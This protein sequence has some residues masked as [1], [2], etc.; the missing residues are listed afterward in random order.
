[1]GC[2]KGCP[3]FL[4]SRDQKSLALA[5]LHFLRG[6]PVA[7]PE[8]L[9]D[10]CTLL[11]GAVCTLVTS[12]EP[13]PASGSGSLGRHQVCVLLEGGVWGGGQSSLGNCELQVEPRCHLYGSDGDS[14]RHEE[15][16]GHM[17]LTGLMTYSRGK[18]LCAGRDLAEPAG[19]RGLVG[20]PWSGI[21]H[22]L[23]PH[24]SAS[25]PVCPRPLS[26]CPCLPPSA[27]SLFVCDS[28]KSLTASS[29]PPLPMSLCV[30]LCPRGLHPYLSIHCCH[31]VSFDP[32]P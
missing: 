11:G 13:E 14:L 20:G 24:I 28:L 16:G 26:P 15:L 21:Q 17:G 2:K 4:P 5:N 1:M 23:P 30:S 32:Y 25:L 18:A 27:L 12:P 29:P 7:G 6:S 9:P 31:C 3:F 8:G 22:C 19:I 10:L